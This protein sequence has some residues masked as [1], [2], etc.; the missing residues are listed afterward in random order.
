MKNKNIW[1]QEIKTK[2]LNDIILPT[3]NLEQIKDINLDVDIYYAYQFVQNQKPEWKECKN[4]FKARLKP[5]ILSGTI[6]VEC[7][8][9]L[10]PLCLAIDDGMG[11]IKTKDR[12]MFATVNYK[13]GILC[14]RKEDGKVEFTISYEYDC[15]CEKRRDDLR[16]IG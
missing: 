10:N 11:S 14:R 12:K 13:H 16:P 15:D 6:T 3:P 2:D 1:M 9:W 4:C 7:L 5:N 8:P